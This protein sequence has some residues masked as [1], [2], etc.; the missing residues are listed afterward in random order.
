[1]RGI[2]G[3]RKLGLDCVWEMASV[4][5][6]NSCVSIFVMSREKDKVTTK[7]LRARMD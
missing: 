5:W 7:T 6:K 2:W 4:G 1:M 3:W